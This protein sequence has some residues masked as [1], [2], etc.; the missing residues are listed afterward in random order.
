MTDRFMALRQLSDNEMICIDGSIIK[1]HQHSTGV[2][3]PEHKEND[4]SVTGNTT[5]SR[6]AVDS[7][8][9]PIDFDI[10]RGRLTTVKRHLSS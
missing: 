5:K 2:C 9:F 4:K 8:G 10:T 1:V 6:M 3:S 7:A